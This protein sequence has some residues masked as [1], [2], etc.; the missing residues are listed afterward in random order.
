MS[1]LFV[2]SSNYYL[3]ASEPL[4]ALPAPELKRIP[5]NLTKKTKLEYQQKLNDL[6]T[7][8]FH[9]FPISQTKLDQMDYKSMKM[10][11][12]TDPLEFIKATE[13]YST[14]DEICQV[15]NFEDSFDVSQQDFL[16]FDL[17]MFLNKLRQMKA[18][19]GIVQQ[20]QDYFVSDLAEH[21]KW[22]RFVGSSLWL[23]QYN[24]HYM[25]SRILYSPNGIAN[26]GFLFDTDW[27]ELPPM[28]L[29]IPFEDSIVKESSQYGG[30]VS[31]VE[32]SHFLNFRTV[33]FPHILPISFD[34]ETGSG[35]KNLYYGPEDPRI[36]LRT[37]PLGFEEPVIV[38]NM[39]DLEL[40]KRVMHLYLP[41]SNHLTTLT[42]RKESFSHIEKNW[43]P[44]FDSPN[45]PHR[46]IRFI[47]SIEPLEIV[48]CDIHSGV[49]D[50][51][52][53]QYKNDKNFIGDLR[54]G[55]QL[56]PLPIDDFLPDSMKPYFKSLENRKVYIGWAREHLNQCG[57]ADAM[58]RPNMITLIED[59]D[60]K[61]NK[62][63]YKIGDVS[64]YFDFNS[65]I[66]P[67]I[68]LEA[69]D[70]GNITESKHL[71]I[72]RNV[73]VP[74]SIAYWDIE[75]VIYDDVSY[76]RDKLTGLGKFPD[77]TT[78]DSFFF[79]DHMG[80]TL[81]S[82]DRDVRIVHL[83][84]FLNY[85]F[86]LPSFSN[87]DLIVNTHNE[88]QVYGFDMNVKCAKWVNKEYCRIYAIDHG[89][90]IL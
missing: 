31:N 55:T 39:K 63:Y 79:V 18:Y 34:Y 15:L 84:G 48:E 44:F 64:S 69:D 6:R 56:L 8:A 74:N 25:V 68:V 86:Q 7:N 61:H 53:T 20:A 80:I 26:Y 14:F 59:Y 4:R 29:E 75:S 16:D 83:R 90:I 52:Q 76:T 2:L 41:F 11:S 43:T 38:F 46:K 3:T 71:C 9:T 66:T 24:C 23:P 47:Y 73:L 67:W 37:N 45:G 13:L 89:A 19:Y 88:F 57:C 28:K 50:N 5:E 60:P 70:D 36:V 17:D 87:S 82:G 65:V 49:C 81:S 35:S 85:L 58:Y 33:E 10:R 77:G 51:L 1:S 12:F 27:N 40:R 22:I 54:G 21:K 42:K 62:Y 78:K 30:W 72:G 32:E